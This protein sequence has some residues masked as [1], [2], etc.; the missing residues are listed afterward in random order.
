[1]LP[2]GGRQV[3]DTLARHLTEKGHRFFSEV[4]T[5]VARLIKEQACYVSEQRVTDGTDEIHS[6]DVNLA[7]YN[8]PDGTIKVSLDTARYR[9]T[10]GLFE[11]RHWGKDHLGI[12]EL[13]YKAI[14]AC[15]MDIRKQMGRS[16]YLSGGGSMIPGFAERLQFEVSS[17]LPQSSHAQVHAGTDRHHAAFIGAS[18]VARLPIFDQLCVSQEEWEQV[19]PDALEKWQNL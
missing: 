6:T 8:L 19:G 3:T 18:V 5:Y 17:M 12:H 2:Y 14:Q 1:R 9:C 13:V 16:I 15:A 7:K 4:E 10:E 11:P